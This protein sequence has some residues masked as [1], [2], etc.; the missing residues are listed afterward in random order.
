MI[1]R[2]CISVLLLFVGHFCKANIAS[3]Y[4]TET[5]ASAAI[6]SKN[7]AVLS[8]TIHIK[9]DKDFKTAKFIIEYTIQSDTI[10]MQ[11]PLLFY[12]E[13]YKGDFLVWIDDSTVDVKNIP[14]EYLNKQDTIF[15][16]FSNSF[17]D[18]FEYDT[19]NKLVFL[20]NG[21]LNYSYSTNQFKYFE[22]I[23]SQ[24]IH[25]VRV[26]YTAVVREIKSGWMKEYSFEYSLEPIKDWKSFKDLNIIVE[27]EG[28]V[29]EL[30]T[31]VGK[32][33]ENI[34]QAKNTWTFHGTPAD[35][36]KFSY[37]PKPNK[38]A[39][40]FIK[41]SP[42]GLIIILSIFV[43]FLNFL[44]IREYRKRKR[45]Q[46]KIYIFILVLITI[47]IPFLLL[48]FYIQS[49][50]FIDNLIGEN[51]GRSHEYTSLVILLY[52]IVLVVYG[53]L[54]WLIDLYI[55]TRFAQKK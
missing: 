15:P 52:P 31:N 33:N 22:S 5:T 1:L 40:I 18:R 6:S 37:L 46:N 4:L 41:I 49:F 2:L 29:K 12:T 13:D 27:Q 26:E 47:F 35:N 20:S 10:G 21:S 50:D 19:Q 8:N 14:K 43:F 36:L 55:K 32:S 42:K 48:V 51:A 9:I 3:P 25:K 38:L 24:D 45:T 44:F 23:I 30:E 39:S 11:I 54:I 7:M 16:V 17:S 53:I 28:K 34:L